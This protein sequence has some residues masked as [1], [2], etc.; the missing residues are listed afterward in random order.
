MQRG[1]GGYGL[2]L[3][4]VRGVLR[5][6]GVECA[7]VEEGGEIGWRDGGVEGGRRKGGGREGIA[8]GLW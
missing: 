2:H 3:V 5:F 7:G 8:R 6:V 1:P 4:R